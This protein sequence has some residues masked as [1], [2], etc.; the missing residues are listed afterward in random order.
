MTEEDID[1]FSA[2]YRG[3]KEEEKDL[4]ASYVKFKGDFKK[5]DPLL[6]RV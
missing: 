2:S 3:S 6:L 1:V 5:Y 4:V